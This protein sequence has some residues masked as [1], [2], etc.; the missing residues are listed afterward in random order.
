MVSKRFGNLECQVFAATLRKTEMK[1][2]LQITVGKT[3]AS[4][5]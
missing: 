4:A 1:N 2:S 5:L 3:I